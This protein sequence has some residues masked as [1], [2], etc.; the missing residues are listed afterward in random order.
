MGLY[1]PPED[2]TDNTNTTNLDLEA[3]LDR[4]IGSKRN[5]ANPSFQ[6]A[7]KWTQIGYEE[8]DTYLKRLDD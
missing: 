1:K 4:S 7:D 5:T 3:L 6:D 8:Q 2:L